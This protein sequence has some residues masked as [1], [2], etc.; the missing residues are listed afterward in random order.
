MKNPVSVILTVLFL[1][2]S[3][4]NTAEPSVS[5]L[6]EMEV[7]F[8]DVGQ[9][10]CAL[11]MCEGENMLIDGGN[12]EDS[13][14]VYS[15]LKSCG[16]KY[17]DCII[18]SH[19]HEDHIG[20]IPGALSLA[21]VGT[22]YSPVAESENSYFNRLKTKLDEKGLEITIPRSGDEFE[23]G[24]AK[25]TFLGP[26]ELSDDDNDN[27]II[28][29]V[30]YNDISFLFTGDAGTSAERLMLDSEEDLS[31]T[32]LKV[33][34][35]GSGESTG[36]RFLRE[37]NPSYAVISCGLN[38]QYGHPHEDLLSRLNDAGAAI[39]RTD[40]NGTVVFTTDG[41]SLS[42]SPEKGKTESAVQ[43]K[44]EPSQ[45]DQIMYIGNLSSKKYHLPTCRSLPAE[46]NT[47]YF[48]SLEEA[49]NSGFSPCGTCKPNEV[50]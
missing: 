47:V 18:A 36:Y 42:V 38:N 48:Y 4:C 3:G 22:V 15:Y 31:A 50:K 7:H 27:S 28:C 6:P 43:K 44:D 37:V 19:P 11:I 8:I 2:L 32:V 21:D 39:Y 13:S 5:T 41:V 49:I 25:V 9:A 17:L 46:K 30:T 20:G 45:T 40:I 10:D 34:H 12:A 24:G 23:L 16:V 29:K 14:L 26:V 1:F 33:G 35:H